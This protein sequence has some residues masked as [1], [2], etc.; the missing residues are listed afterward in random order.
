MEHKKK[1]A[2]KPG[3][4]PEGYQE[5]PPGPRPGTPNPEDTQTH[6]TAEHAEE[7]F[8]RYQP[9]NPKVMPG[10]LQEQH[11]NEELTEW[12]PKQN[13]EEKP[14]S[15]EVE[16][17]LEAMQAEDD[18]IQKPIWSLAGLNDE[19]TILDLTPDEDKIEDED[20]EDDATETIPNDGWAVA[21]F[22]PQEYSPV[23]Y[24]YGQPVAAI[25]GGTDAAPVAYV[26][27]SNTYYQWSS[28]GR[29]KRIKA[30]PKSI[31]AGMLRRATRPR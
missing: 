28:E 19:D 27:E 14:L 7:E 26:K 12:S 16:E 24:Y 30:D 10:Y 6:P 5:P 29:W 9:K 4:N 22:L 3:E 1:V 31:V 8:V 15:P 21:P 11:M 17:A 13:E 2:P 23:L 25:Y 20:S 18:A